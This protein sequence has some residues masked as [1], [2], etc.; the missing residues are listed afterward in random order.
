MHSRALL[1]VMALLLAFLA[2]PA[3]SEP[4]ELQKISQLIGRNQ[5]A[6]AEKNL[7]RYLAAHPGD[8]RGTFI[9]GILLGEQKKTAEAIRL[10]NDLIKQNP[11]WPEPYNNL[12]VL[13]AS[14]GQYERAR[15]TLETALRTHPSYAA[16]HD[17]L[18][19][20]YAAM[21]SEAYGK[22]LK[23]DGTM[24]R[25]QPRLA[26]VGLPYAE[27]RALAMAANTLPATPA[28]TPVAAA[29]PAPIAKPV[30]IAAVSAKPLQAAPAPVAAATAPPATA[31]A[32][33]PPKDEAAPMP[34]DQAAP[35][36]D[37][38]KG[39]AKAWARQDVN[40]YLDYYAANFKTPKGES[41]RA[42]EQTR[43]SRIKSPK[44]IAVDVS[45]I[46]TEIDGNRAEVR[47]KQNYRADRIAKRTNKTLILNKSGNRW[48][49]VE[50]LAR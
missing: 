8:V 14:Q 28:P 5:H 18:S 3:H 48:L 9:K 22:A 33:P 29:A 19:G 40:K 10:Y 49:I 15:Q 46:K 50:E 35:I 13:Y 25:P 1:A 31:P 43:R 11:T 4:D 41:R 7:D 26:M 17:N 42:W 36:E 2:P 30:P 44:S 39:W 21:A 38:V 34:S 16:V 6:E 37:T 24:T 27:K 20:I 45:N 32:T 47:F 12:A 23:T